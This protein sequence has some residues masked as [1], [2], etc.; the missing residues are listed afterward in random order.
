MA[1]L[2]TWGEEFDRA[3]F[4]EYYKEKDESGN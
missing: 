2:N 4:P 3:M 1:V